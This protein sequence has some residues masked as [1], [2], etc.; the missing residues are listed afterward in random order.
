MTKKKL[1]HPGL[2]HILNEIKVDIELIDE[3]LARFLDDNETHLEHFMT[4]LKNFVESISSA[5]PLS[6]PKNARV[7]SPL[8]E[9]QAESPARSPTKMQAESPTKG[10]ENFD[11][12]QLLR[13]KTRDDIGKS[14]QL[15]GVSTKE[16][17][18]NMVNAIRAEGKETINNIKKT[19][20]SFDTKK[21]GKLKLATCV[22]IIMFN[23]KGIKEDLALKFQSQY[24]KVYKDS[25]MDYQSFIDEYLTDKEA[26]PPSQRKTDMNINTIMVTVAAA[27]KASKV[28]INYAFRFFDEKLTGNVTI[29]DFKKLFAWIKANIKQEEFDYLIE[30]FRTESFKIDYTKFLTQIEVS[31]HNLS[32]IYD[33]SNWTVASEIVKPELLEKIS[34]NS[35]YIKF[36]INQKLK[37]TTSPVQLPLL[38]ALTLHKALGN[39]KYEFT[40]KEIDDVVNYA[41]LGSQ[42]S[43]QE[44]QKKLKDLEKVDVVTELINLDHFFYSIPD[45]LANRKDINTSPQARTVNIKPLSEE[46]A[47]QKLEEKHLISKIKGILKDRDVTLWDSI[48]SS[49]MTIT[50][51]SKISLHE[52]GV[53]LNSL[54]LGLTLKEKL[55][56]N[57]IADPHDTK[58]VDLKALIDV[59]EEK[60]LSEKVMKVILEKL[61]IALFFNDLSFKAAFD[62]FDVDKDDSISFNEF[63]FG[64][65]QLDLG[66]SIFEIQQ[67]A[68]MIDIDK[69]GV[70]SR[71][72]FTQTFE[73]LFKKY[74]VDPSKDLSFSLY[75]KIKNLLSVKGIDLLDCLKDVDIHRKGWLTY[76]AF[77]KALNNFGRIYCYFFFYFMLG[78][79]NLQPYQINAL[80][81]LNKIPPNEETKGKPVLRRGMTAMISPKNPDY[82]VYYEGF[83]ENLIVKNCLNLLL[84]VNREKLKRT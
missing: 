49:D 63:I 48:V 25:T 14:I 73:E 21:T 52:F 19:F 62:Y 2:R 41:I 34:A 53:I 23:C 10:K 3:I 38:P 67:M 60:A 78:L 9:K 1:D 54:N 22:N 84:N 30:F 74:M 32:V 46:E 51:Q 31:N 61:G 4:K 5:A 42:V 64:F 79:E 71:A 37:E 39:F 18:Q 24:E 36:M 57:K 82:K 29:E 75:A 20:E 77:V 65:S 45:I 70:I 13:T 72:E 40:L 26:P 68:T 50:E 17:I 15:K 76:D 16:H 43:P 35:E 66:L 56:L 33:K 59:L 80:L 58:R 81:K 11:L 12:S 7:S 55:M 27:I 28:N 6:P 8:F 44:A 47:K 83:Y 69:N